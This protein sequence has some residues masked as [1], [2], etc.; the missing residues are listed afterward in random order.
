MLHGYGSNGAD[1]IGWASYWQDVLLDAVF[2]SP[3]TPMQCESIEIGLDP[4]HLL[5][6][7]HQQ[8]TQGKHFLPP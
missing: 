3:D 2:I 1:L 6:R 4:A 7:Q 8:I 5:R